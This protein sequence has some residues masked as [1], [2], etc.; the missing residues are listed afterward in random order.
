MSSPPSLGP[1]N[2]PRTRTPRSRE[3]SF[4]RWLAVIIA[5]VTLLVGITTY[6]QSDASGLAATLN[7]RAQENELASTGVRSRGQVELAF[8]EFVV[9]REY[10]EMYGARV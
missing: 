4:R 10:D 8:A 6:L 9:A 2:Q 1:E 7:R 3:E 5:L